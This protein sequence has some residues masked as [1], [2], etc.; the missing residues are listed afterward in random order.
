[1]TQ[2]NFSPL[3][4][5]RRKAAAHQPEMAFPGGDRAAWDEWFR[6][7]QRKFR[8]LLGPMPEKV[9]LNAEV[10]SSVIDGTLVRERVVFDSEEH[11]SVPC[12]VLR[13]ADM[14]GDGS[15]AAIV[16]CHGHGQ[17]GKDSVAGI[18]GSNEH[19]AEIAVH[20]YDYGRQ[21]AEAGFLTI[22]PDLRGFGERRDWPNPFPE[23]DPCN[24]YFIMGSLLGFNTL[25]LNVWDIS[26]CVDYLE[27]R[28][29]VDSNRIG[30]MGLSYGGTVTCFA[31]AAERRIK[32]A[33]IIGYVNPFGA[34][35]YRNARFCGA[36]ILPD[37]FRY[38]DVPDI[39]GLIA[40]RPLLLEIGI[41]D[42]CF[43]IHDML[44]GAEKV[45]EIYKAAGATDNF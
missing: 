35:A 29:E 40:P 20:N 16:C 5:W 44:K 31:A 37:L 34:F 27:T 3:A 11:M 4:Y 7:G 24:M 42:T 18:R 36:Q 1:M 9:P 43:Y 23:R 26:R 30:L 32:A 2:R 28:D 41:Y 19:K 14:K 25:A 22:C 13:P 38:F 33:D 15:H 45:K 6:T 10:E 39:A 21:M 12:Q 17:F 8:E